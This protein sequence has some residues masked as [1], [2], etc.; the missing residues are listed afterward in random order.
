MEISVNISN[1]TSDNHIVHV[2]DLF[3]HA[4]R[5]VRGS[6]FALAEDGVSPMFAINASA[7]GNGI[8]AYSCEGGPSLSEIDVSDGSSIEIR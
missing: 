5:E 6:P 2:Y 1:K 3:A 4:R 7:N 8:A